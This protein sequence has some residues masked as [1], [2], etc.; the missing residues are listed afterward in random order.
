MVSIVIMVAGLSSRFGKSRPKQM[1]IVGDNNE[2]LI[3]YLVNQ[4]LSQ[5]FS[6]IILITNRIT[7]YLFKNIFGNTYRNKKVHYVQQYYDTNIRSR[8]WGTADAICAIEQAVD[9][10]FIL[11]N[12]DDIYG[13]EPFKK[14]F[15]FAKKKINVIGGAKIINSNPRGFFNKGII[16]TENNKV[17]NIKEM[18]NISK[19]THPELMSKLGNVNF[20]GLNKIIIPK[21]KGIVDKFKKKHINDKK[22]ECFLP[23]S[24]SELINNGDME[25]TWFEIKNQILGLTRYEDVEFVKKQIRIHLFSTSEHSP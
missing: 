10:Y 5:N 6:S 24:L 11:L 4:A 13:L 15:E 23:D 2:T 14:G 8:P 20:I 16:T 21:L 25:M 12:G 9:D 1:E 17:I 19:Q 3:E 22:I 7:E 18:L